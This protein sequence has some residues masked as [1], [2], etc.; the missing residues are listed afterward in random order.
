MASSA[1]F[2]G[3]LLQHPTTIVLF[4]L[5]E[6]EVVVATARGCGEF[7]D[8]REMK[9]SGKPKVNCAVDNGRVSYAEFFVCEPS[10]IEIITGALPDEFGSEPFVSMVVQKRVRKAGFDGYLSAQGQ[11]QHPP[12]TGTF[13]WQRLQK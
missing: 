4:Y 8:P 2:W 1:T 3:V 7:T 12:F 5:L 13:I 6:F 11:S 9:C 10:V